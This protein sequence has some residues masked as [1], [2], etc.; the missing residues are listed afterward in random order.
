MAANPTKQNLP[1]LNAALAL[2]RQRVAD[3]MESPEGLLRPKAALQL[4]LRS[5]MDSVSTIEFLRTLPADNPY[6]A[7]M[8]A[9]GP[10]DI[11]GANVGAS[12]STDKKAARLAELK[13]SMS[14]F[15]LN[16]GYT[17][18]SGG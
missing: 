7:A 18:K 16:R 12:M 17:A 15:N 8:N 10:I 1:S 13:G 11:G 2:D 9:E 14:Q 4:A 6:L 5:T 3:I